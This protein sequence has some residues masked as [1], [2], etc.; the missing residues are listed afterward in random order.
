VSSDPRD[1]PIQVR[2][3]VLWFAFLGPPL[4]WVVHI[5][6][7]YPLVP[8]ACALELPW[9]LH[10]ITLATLAVT[11]AATLAAA[12]IWRR[13]RSASVRNA[14]A[15]RIHYMAVVGAMLGILFAIVILAELV[16]ALIQDPCLDVR[17]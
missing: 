10:R 4:A 15:R 6:A 14:T 8:T 3:S 2:R 1:K 7:R 17:R 9:V 16:P 13:A 12:S 11:L 5:G